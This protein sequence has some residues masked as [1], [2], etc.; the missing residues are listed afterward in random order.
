[1]TTATAKPTAKLNATEQMVD[2]AWGRMQL[3]KK[4]TGEPLFV[5]HHDVGNPGWLPFYEALAQKHTVYV[6]S[7]PGYPKSTLPE[8]ARTV[9]DLATLHL[10]LINELG[11]QSV[12]A[13]GLGFGGWIAAEMATMDHRLFKKLVLVNSMGIQPKEGEIL[14]QFLVSTTEYAKLCFH[15]PKGFEQQ[16]G[17]PDID[18]LEFWELCREMT[19]RVA[20]KP[21]M[22][23]QS[24]PHLVAGVRTPTLLVA[25]KYDK[26]V[27]MDCAKRYLGGLP[28]AR[29]EVLDGAGHFAEMEK[30]NEL[31]KLV[32]DFLAK[33]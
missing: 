19:T 6:P 3:L 8:W 32:N 33:K 2:M 26:V 4:G 27:P 30:P 1:M 14:D 20:W 11:L 12:S 7:H 15:Q 23:N 28:N 18:Q 25:A 16:Y 9:R 5:Y 13:V 29:L 17:E 31:A 10:W 22:F 24:M 21:Y